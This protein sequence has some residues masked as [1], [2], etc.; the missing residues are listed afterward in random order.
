[1]ADKN[2]NI[3]KQFFLSFFS[4]NDYPGFARGSGG[5]VFLYSFLLIV[6]TY[7]VTFAVPSASVAPYI[8]GIDK[9]VVD[10]YVPWFELKNGRFDVEREF[11]YEDDFGMV[12]IYATPD[13]NFDTSR[14]NDVL[15]SFFQGFVFS[16][17][18]MVLKQAG[19]QIIE[20]SL[21]A[22]PELSISRDYLYTLIPLVKFL[23]VFMYILVFVIYIV[24]YMIGWLVCSAAGAAINAIIRA[25]IS[26]GEVFRL[27]AYA[28]T[29]PLVIK[30]A[31]YLIPGYSMN[32]WLF[33]VLF[34]VYMLLA[35]RAVKNRT[36][37]D[38]SGKSAQPP[39]EQ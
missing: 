13:E 16:P 18:A 21:S 26:F 37:L 22:A 27:T 4:F 5:K 8:Y 31:L 20:Y 14:A 2:K 29:V 17:G 39:P 15:G 3:F 24:A 30:T 12:L 32:F 38:D 6:I 9:S 25:P 7:I 36:V 23:V 10:E 34:A 1:M 33:Y 28:R 11:L 19:G 35:L